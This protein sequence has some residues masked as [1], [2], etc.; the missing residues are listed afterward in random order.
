METT[1]PVGN[2]GV[3]TL[4]A[5]EE[6]KNP[7][8]N[9]NAIAFVDMF[10]FKE[11]FTKDGAIKWLTVEEENAQ[12]IVRDSDMRGVGGGFSAQ[13]RAEACATLRVKISKAKGKKIWDLD[14]ELGKIQDRVL[15]E[16][17]EIRAQQE[18]LVFQGIGKI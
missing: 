18:G 15:A 7:K 12:M 4:K 8:P 5:T 10:G 11:E 9:E 17:N 2:Q 13:V 3:K 6:E 14:A 1:A 16:E